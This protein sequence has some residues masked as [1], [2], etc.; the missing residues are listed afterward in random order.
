M[1]PSKS[2]FH[3]QYEPLVAAT[4]ARGESLA[5]LSLDASALRQQ[6]A[7]LPL[8]PKSL[9]VE[10]PKM[11]MRDS[12]VPGRLV[13]QPAHAGALV[14][15]NGAIDEVFIRRMCCMLIFN[16]Y[17]CWFLYG[18]GFSTRGKGYF[19]VRKGL[20]RSFLRNSPPLC[21]QSGCLFACFLFL[22]LTYALAGNRAG[23]QNV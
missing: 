7:S 6:D 19:A 13:M 16:F 1:R 12:Q 22:D 11:L 9:E 21:P 8:K 3:P 14:S 10:R 23:G 17:F 4:V 5:N 15:M 2:P 18:R 20:W